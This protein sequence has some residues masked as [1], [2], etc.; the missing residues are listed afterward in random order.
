MRVRISTRVNGKIPMRIFSIFVM[1]VATV[2]GWVIVNSLRTSQTV[3]NWDAVECTILKSEVKRHTIDRY[4]F[5]ATF[6]YEVAGQK[7]RSSDIDRP[8][9]GYYFSSIS[10]RLPLLERFA[11]GSR[12]ACRVDPANPSCAV[13]V[14]DET[15]NT[16]GLVLALAFVGVFATFG[17]CM[18]W[19][20]LGGQKPRR[21]RSSRPV[22]VLFIVFG[23]VFLCAGVGVWIAYSHTRLE[24]SG[25]DSV[26]GR[27]LY[28]GL[29]SHSGSK[30]ATLYAPCIAYAYEVGGRE[31]ENDRYSAVESSSSNRQ[32]KQDIVN[33]YTTGAF[34]TVYYSPDN[35]AKSCLV[36]PNE[37]SQNA[38]VVA[39]L[40]VFVVAG[41]FLIGVGVRAVLPKRGKISKENAWRYGLA[42]RR[43]LGT[44]VV[45][46]LVF[47]CF[48]NAISWTF[49]MVFLSDF[50]WST[51][52]L[53]ELLVVLFPVIGIVF[54]VKAVRSLQKAL[55]GVHY[56]VTL[57]SDR[58]VP[59]GRVQVNCE[60]TGGGEVM[61]VRLVVA[62]WDTALRVH[63]EGDPDPHKPARQTEVYV[64]TSSPM[65]RS[66][67]AFFEIPEA[68]DSSN[69]RWELH[70]VSVSHGRTKTEVF[71]LPIME[72]LP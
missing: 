17:V 29:R 24:Y 4:L 59:G 49:A 40:G 5:T 63:L 21:K 27:V 61:S 68:I 57:S 15:S 23:L 72:S 39:L 69:I 60:Q 7:L 18:F 65:P 33:G 12:H 54:A 62:Q 11:V 70:L 47:A 44:E 22:A 64:G 26:E 55:C 3:A 19:A 28:A 14:V 32:R 8:S 41:L 34:V 38:I 31:Y 2:F 20:S 56:K 9:G 25:F 35:P 43:R 67:S 30:G 53:P 42:L 51:A 48:W 16:L 13:L 52:E 6:E 37:S 1:L 58:L 50:T 71:S 36:K 66:W 10:K 45:G 46:A